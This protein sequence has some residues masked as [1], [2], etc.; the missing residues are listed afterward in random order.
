MKKKKN[1]MTPACISHFI[2]GRKKKF[3]YQTTKAWLSGP[4]KIK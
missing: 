3:V 2:K 1:T 4:V